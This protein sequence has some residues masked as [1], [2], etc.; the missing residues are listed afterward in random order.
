MTSSF[1]MTGLAG[2]NY[3]SLFR[4]HIKKVKPP[5]FGMAVAYVSASG[6]NVVKSILDESGV[7]EVRLVTD[8]KDGVTHPK[9]RH[10]GA[11]AVG[12]ADDRATCSSSAK[13]ASRAARRRPGRRRSRRSLSARR[14]RRLTVA[15]HASAKRRTALERLGIA[16][17]SG[18][19][20]R[21]YRRTC[22]PP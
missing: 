6:F 13:R 7:G 9:R 18:S 4:R 20:D 19:A 3:K 14:R 10:G 16:W 17:R 8:T 22:W 15:D 5:V 2:S 21:S 12:V 1:A 11:R